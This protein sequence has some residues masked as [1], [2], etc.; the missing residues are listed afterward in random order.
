MN[1][2]GLP[3]QVAETLSFVSTL[4]TPAIERTGEHG[5]E[6]PIEFRRLLTASAF[7]AAVDFVDFTVIPPGTTIGKHYHVGNE[8]LYYVAAGRPLVCVN[9]DERR[10][11]AR[12][13]AVVR[14]GQW[15]EL[16]NDTEDDVEIF[17]VQVHL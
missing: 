3:V 8:E 17:V 16:R 1:E 12:D 11:D 9:G 4:E 15:H 14:S 6:G 5:G 2:L 7:A 10:L 13:V